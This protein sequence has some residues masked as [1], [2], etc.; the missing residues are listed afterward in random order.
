MENGS[1]AVF[2][3]LRAFSYVAEGDCKE[4]TLSLESKLEKVYG[5]R[6]G[7]GQDAFAL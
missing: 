2:L 5:S 1:F 4:V 7:R 3:V 6:L